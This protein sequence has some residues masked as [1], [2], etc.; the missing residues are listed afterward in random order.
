MSV[1][2][3]WVFTTVYP[4]DV[5][6]LKD[7]HKALFDH[8]YSLPIGDRKE[9][10]YIWEVRVVRKDGETLW[11]LQ[12]GSF[13]EIDHDGKPMV[14]FDIL[15]DTTQFKKDKSMTLTM[16]RNAESEKFKLY[17]PISRSQPFSRREV[18]F[19]RLL[20]EGRTSEE[21]ADTLHI[22]SHTVDTHRRHM[23]KKAGVNDT[24]KLV[25]YAREN[26]LL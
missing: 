13:I 26:G 11:L 10:K 20:S 9:H 23:L 24:I 15:T 5:Q 17:F 22:S 18:E 8:Y 7:L 16:F 6:R 21:I 3:A 1:Y 2:H 4:E 19:I 25:A 14:T 12:Q